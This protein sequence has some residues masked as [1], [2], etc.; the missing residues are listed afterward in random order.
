MP[1]KNYA[2]ILKVREDI[3]YA[4]ERKKNDINGNPVYEG[5]LFRINEN[6]GYK[7]KLK[8]MYG[9]KNDFIERL[10]RIIQEEKLYEY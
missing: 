10:E 2:N 3:F 7:I 1:V 5:I 8:C 4:Y 9:G 6:T